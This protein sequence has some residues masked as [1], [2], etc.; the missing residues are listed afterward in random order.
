MNVNHK[1]TVNSRG[2]LFYICVIAAFGCGSVACNQVSPDNTMSEK[3]YDIAYVPDAK[4]KIDGRLDEPAWDNAN[5]LSDFTFPWT[6]AVAPTT[7]FR[8]IVDD[9]NLY[10]CYRVWDDDIVLVEPYEKPSDSIGED[11]VE[12]VL[13]CDRQ[14]KKYFATEI[15]LHGRVLDFQASYHRKFDFSWSWPDLQT[16]GTLLDDGYTVEG[17]IPLQTLESLGLGSLLSGDELII[18]LFRAE[19]SHGPDGETIE[20]WISWIPPQV[21]EPDFH[22]PSGFGTARVVR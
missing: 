13:S 11:R 21:A 5:L 4:I 8:A 14:L 12:I 15:D 9:K 6:D 20:D 7:H 16:A 19:F 18:G 2:W 1:N 22:I 3:V 17:A 10:F